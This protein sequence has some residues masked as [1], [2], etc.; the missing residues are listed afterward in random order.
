MPTRRCSSLRL[1]TATSSI[2]MLIH[3]RSAVADVDA[4]MD[5]T[6]TLWVTLYDSKYNGAHV[7][8]GVRVF[9]RVSLPLCVKW[10][11]GRANCRGP[12]TLISLL[13]KLA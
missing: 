5:G 7:F 9:G 12:D 4:Q 13:F 10:K 6:F 11:R 3:P 2:V 1:R 8:C